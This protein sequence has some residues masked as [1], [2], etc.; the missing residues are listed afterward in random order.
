MTKN[1]CGSEW[2][3]PSTVTWCSAIASSKALCVRGGARLISSASSICVNTGP[4]WKR[5]SRAVGSKI[6]TPMMSDG[7]RSDVNCMR[8]KSRP[9]VADIARARVVLPRPRQVFDQQVA[10]GKQG[11]QRQ[12]HFPGFAQHQGVDLRRRGVERLAQGVG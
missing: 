11:R 8:W 6:D 3:V 7:N 5:N 12:A 9:S 2:L 1:G 10:A 4:A